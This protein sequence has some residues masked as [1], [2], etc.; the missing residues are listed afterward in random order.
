LNS[1]WLELIKIRDVCNISIEEKRATKEIGS[2]LEVDLEIKL[3]KKLYELTKDT[4]FA[5]LCITSK[6]SVIKNDKDEIVI[7]TK[8]AK[9]NKCSLCWKIKVDTCER[10]SCPI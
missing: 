1:K 9:G 10:S 8:K 2:S 7:G 3:N 4:N 5:E 6:S